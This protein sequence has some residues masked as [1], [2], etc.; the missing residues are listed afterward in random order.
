MME[1]T[2][3]K[4]S[5]ITDIWRE[6]DLLFLRQERGLIRLQPRTDDILRVS[7]TSEQ[8]FPDV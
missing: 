8:S 1:V 6:A 7:F 4:G 2:P 5:A 3:R